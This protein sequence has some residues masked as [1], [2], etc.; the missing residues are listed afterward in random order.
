MA[1]N[2]IAQNLS[3][4]VSESYKKYAKYIIQDRALPDLRDGLKPVQRRILY[5]MYDLNITSTQAYKKSARTVGEVIGKYHPHG[6]SSI[7]E[8]MVRMSQDWKN[9]LCLL[10]MHG[11][12]GSIDGDNAAAM[13]YTETRLAK[14]ADLMLEHLDKKTVNFAYNFDDS[15][16]EP[17]ILPTLFPNLLIN[18]AT[19]IASGYT[20]N[21]PPHN[22]NEVFDCLI[23]KI[24]HPQASET[25]LLKILPAP[26]FPTG[27][28]IYQLDECKK[29]LSTGIGKFI[30]RAR[31]EQKT[32]LNKINQ[33]IITQIPYETNKAEI[34]KSIDQMIYDQ[35]VYGI[36]EIRD[37]SDAHGI[38]IVI[39]VKKDV[40]LNNLISYLFKKTN[41]QITYHTKMVAI[42]NRA[43][44]VFNLDLYCQAFI[45]H[46]LEILTKVDQFNLNKINKRMEIVLGL[47]KALDVI[48]E[49][50]K[51]IRAS[52]NKTDAAINLIKR[53]A[54]SENQ[55]EAIVMMRLYRLTQTDLLS[56]QEEYN[57]LLAQQTL[58]MNRL[59][60]PQIMNDYLVSLY[61]EYKKTFGYKRKSSLM[62]EDCN[63]KIDEMQMLEETDLHVTISANGYIKA[64]SSKSFQTNNYV[65]VGLK[66]NDN[67][68]A[69]LYLSNYAHLVFI[70]SAGRLIYLPVNKIN[71]FKWKDVGMHLNDFCTWNLHEKIIAVFVYEQMIFTDQ[72]L[73]IT[74]NNKGKLLSLEEFNNFEKNKIKDTKVIKLQDDDELI[75]AQIVHDEASQVLC[76][77]SQAKALVFDVKE[78]NQANKNAIGM[79]VMGL[80]DDDYLIAAHLIT[81]QTPYLWM[82]NDEWNKMIKVKDLSP[83]KRGLKGLNLNPT[84]KQIVLTNAVLF[85]ESMIFNL[86]MNNEELVCT[87]LQYVHKEIDNRFVKNDYGIKSIYTNTYINQEEK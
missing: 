6:D 9:N 2:I 68:I 8:A 42:Y 84:K 3:L 41:L 46:S 52:K 40:D 24:K 74:K 82:F 16:Q 63:I 17:V 50:I 32:D 49:I 60:N 15:E 55:A 85:N 62:V 10:D 7:Y 66:E 78:I 43:P 51:I 20:T 65:D 72:W 64:I 23:Y 14:V 37:E 33:L 13:R 19:G 61:Q 67:L 76:L 69:H 75:A 21:I 44:I 73:L 80:S 25:Q 70:T 54:F 18:G 30:V 79:K 77:S 81:S 4:V 38:C 35:Q 57:N 12:K 11:N 87:K 36:L 34:I 39:D 28:L 31:I 45:E 59:E 29:A 47:I 71:N 26:D 22:P 86:K 53:F 48:D 58:L 56:L 27:G 1:N 5:A 83:S